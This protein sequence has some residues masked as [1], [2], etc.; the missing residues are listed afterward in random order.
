VTGAPTNAHSK[1]CTCGPE[2][3]CKTKSDGGVCDCEK[4]GHQH[5]QKE[6]EKKGGHN[7]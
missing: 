3:K 6:G 1:T 2:C 7:H 4:K 5:V